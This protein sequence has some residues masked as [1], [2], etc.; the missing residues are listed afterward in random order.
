MKFKRFLS[1]FFAISLSFNSNSIFA[2]NCKSNNNKEQQ[3]ITNEASKLKSNMSTAAKVAIPVGI[4][5]AA[6]T[7]VRYIA[8]SF[9]FMGSGSCGKDNWEDG[10]ASSQYIEH[11]DLCG[12]TLKAVNPKSN[13]LGKKCV[14]VF[15][16]NA[17]CAA[18]MVDQAYGFRGYYPLNK[19]LQRGANLVGMDYRGYGNSKHISKL[20]ISESTLYAD[21]EKMYDY[22]RNQLGYKPEDIILYAH[23]L[24]GAISSHVLEYASSKGE[25]L[26]GIILASPINNLYSAASAFTC[27]L[28]GAVARAVT[29]SDLNTEKNLS[30]VKN[31]DIPVFICSGDN[32][33]LLSLVKTKLH[34]K[35]ISMGYTNVSYYIAQECDHNNISKMF[36]VSFPMLRGDAVSGS[37]LYD[38][39]SYLYDTYISKLGGNKQ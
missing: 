30:K 4:T 5:L 33:D 7:G 23:S 3:V 19:L 1:V 39:E 15:S 35:I 17:G 22:V 21:G 25:N 12:R 10:F 11:G 14:L 28:G 32:R 20:R 37:Y 36:G 34:E 13:D 26:C 27:K 6:L 24:G 2:A 9:I 18:E 31:K 29:M 16:P 38:T 8:N